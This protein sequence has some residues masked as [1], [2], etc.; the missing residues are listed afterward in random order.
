MLG[1]ASIFLEIN[2][3]IENMNVRIPNGSF[4]KVETIERIRVFGSL[5]L[6]FELYISLLS[7]NLLSINKMIKD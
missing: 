1:D 7:C 5:V 3:M 6:V 2:K 4:T